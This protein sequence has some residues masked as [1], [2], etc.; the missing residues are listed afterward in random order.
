MPDNLESRVDAQLRDHETRIE[1]LESSIA[2]IDADVVEVNER[3][4]D[5]ATRADAREIKARADWILM[6]LIA[7]VAIVAAQLAFHVG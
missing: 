6:L 2:R 5:L 1:A 7:V 3:I 4:S